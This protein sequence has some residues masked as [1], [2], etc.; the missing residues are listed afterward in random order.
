[1]WQGWQLTA[2]PRE[3]YRA[4]RRTVMKCPKCGFNSFEYLDNCKKCGNDLMGFKASLGLRP[5]FLAPVMAGAASL[6][7]METVA[8]EPISIAEIGGNAP[9]ELFQWDDASAT[10]PP[11]SESSSGDLPID[12][13]AE[14]AKATS[15]A[16]A[17][18]FTTPPPE[19]FPAP[20]QEP[21]GNPFGEFSFTE[22][23]GPAAATADQNFAF[24]EPA[25]DEI[26]VIQAAEAEEF[27]VDSFAEFAAD[28]PV[29][30]S[31]S[32]TSTVRGDVGMDDHL[33]MEE[34]IEPAPGEEQ[35]PAG[36]HQ[37]T[38][39]ELSALFAELEQLDKKS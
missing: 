25:A 29:G 34:A 22:A 2:G 15:M 14:P 7:A 20:Q 3:T 6:A 35:P 16:E 33:L 36:R 13:A 10:P 24:G 18:T 9:N 11:S 4:A 1:V 30:A 12:L 28:E 8:E 32:L 27:T 21:A 26:T 39:D 38:Q 23:P 17:F 31:A 37:A 19:P 5:A